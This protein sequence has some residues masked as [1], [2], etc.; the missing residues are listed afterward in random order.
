[1]ACRWVSLYCRVDR[2]A[3]QREVSAR[4]DSLLDQIRPL[5]MD[6][7]LDHRRGPRPPQN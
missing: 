5:A 3:S 4:V 6:R 2:G 7:D 1:M